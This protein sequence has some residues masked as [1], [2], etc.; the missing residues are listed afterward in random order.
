M[1]R[2]LDSY[3]YKDFGFDVILKN[4][5]TKTVRGKERPVINLPVIKTKVAIALLTGSEKLTGSQLK[6]IRTFVFEKSF[7]LIT[8]FTEGLTKSA[9]ASWEKQGNVITGL[10]FEQEKDIRYFG[11]SRLKDAWFDTN[12][13]KLHQIK[14]Y[15]AK[16][17]QKILD[18]ND[19][20]VKFGPRKYVF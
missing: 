5:P 10:S 7:I 11:L 16:K 6:F 9:L 17:S 20:S 18:T 2:A 1:S 8:S 15:S 12:L 19:I 14:N 13:Q 3:I 4:V